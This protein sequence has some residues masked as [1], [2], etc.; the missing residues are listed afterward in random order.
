[1]KEIEGLTEAHKTYSSLGDFILF[2]KLINFLGRAFF[3]QDKSEI[4]N[5]LGNQIKSNEKEISDLEVFHF[6][7]LIFKNF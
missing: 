6:C 2:I 7:C 5:M 4:M 1:M 3:Y